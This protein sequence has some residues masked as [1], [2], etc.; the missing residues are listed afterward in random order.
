MIRH[1]PFT[2]QHPMMAVLGVLFAVAFVVTYGPFF[3]AAGAAVALFYAGRAMHRAALHRR[4]V[5]AAIAARADY[6]HRVDARQRYDGV[7]RAVS[8]PAR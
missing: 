2:E 3:V 5:H 8:A 7:V 6:E 4:A 1:R